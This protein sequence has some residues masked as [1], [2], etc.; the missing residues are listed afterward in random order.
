MI[1]MHTCT[2]GSCRARV[3]MQ[4]SKIFMSPSVAEKEL[5]RLEQENQ[6]A[7]YSLAGSGYSPINTE[8][9]SRTLTTH[10]SLVKI[11]TGDP[12]FDKI[13]SLSSEEQLQLVCDVFNRVALCQYGITIPEDFLRLSLCGMRRLSEVGKSNIIR[14]LCKGLGTMR[15]DGSD[16]IFPTTRMPIG[17]LQYMVEFFISKPGHRVSHS[18]TCCTINKLHVM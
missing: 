4:L 11:C 3:L 12:L 9:V 1:E 16:S 5:C 15:L 8:H 17:L 10:L 18:I 6:E 14:G 13:T 2:D 7:S